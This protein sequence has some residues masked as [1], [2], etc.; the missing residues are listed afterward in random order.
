MNH[1][2]IT[3][4]QVAKILNI[5]LYK[6]YE[7]MNSKNFPTVVIGEKNGRKQYRVDGNKLNDWISKGGCKS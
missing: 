7:L 5:S 2:L 1:Q 3:A 4:K 6:T